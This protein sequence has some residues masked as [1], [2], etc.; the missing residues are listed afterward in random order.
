M[1]KELKFNTEAR[2]ALMVGVN[3]LANAV[4]V[5]LGPKGKNVM[6]C[7]GQGSPLVTKDG[8][9]VAKEITLKDNFENLGAQMAKDVASKTSDMAG[10]GTTTATVLAQA[11]AIEGLKYVAAGAN[12]MDIKRGIDIAVE[13][14]I[15]DLTASSKEIESK[16]D[17]AQVAAISGNNDQE[18]GDLI[19]DA[20]EK[21]GNNGV[22]TIEESKTAETTL[23][24]VE[25]MEFDRG[26]LSPYFATDT[27]KME[28]VLD[29]PKILLLDGKVSSMREI[30]PMLEGTAKAG[31]PLLI[32]ADDV[33]GEALATLVVN[34]IRGTIKI[35]A[36]KAPG[37]GDRRKDM[38]ADLA[39]LTGG[40]LVSEEAGV[41]LEDVP[42]DV[43]GEARTVI[44]TKDKTVII[45]G[46]GSEKD[47]NH[48]INI[49][50][51]Q[52]N[53]TESDYS[54]EKLQER[55]AKLTGGVAVIYVGAATEVEMKEKKD[56]YDDALHATR[57]AVEEGIVTGGGVA[58]I[59]SSR[60]ID[61]LKFE[62]IDQ[63]R[64]AA[65]IKIAIEAPL[66]Q[67]ATNAGLEASVIANN[68]KGGGRTGFGFNAKTEI[69]EDLD[70]AGVIDPAKVTKSALINAASIASMILTTDCLIVEAKTDTSAQTMD[71]MSQMGGIM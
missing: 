5:T 2:E 64:G 24:V 55:L 4:K 41:K 9:S 23:D 38:L 71:Q 13:A 54:R 33:E 60:V 61:D 25:G 32:I 57:A 59:R 6:I 63:E 28:C 42:L 11:I 58:L 3:K 37:F 7:R 53:T 66:R 35:A 21:V 43:L 67:I 44:I 36:I 40:Q 29:S 62:N 45:E 52:I 51:N 14:M 10:D 18:I 27:D 50:K 1:S 20:M 12:P 46:K 15:K 47:V 30:V 34:K 49:I 8:V 26:Y 22:I 17:I 65:I 68:V 19:A 56:R 16:K 48:R 39:I 70:K 69:Y 31:R